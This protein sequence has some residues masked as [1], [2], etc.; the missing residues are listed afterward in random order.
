[1]VVVTVVVVVIR[2]KLSLHGQ[3][4]SNICMG[5]GISYFINVFNEDC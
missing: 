5:R 3:A 4:G 2:N 1:M